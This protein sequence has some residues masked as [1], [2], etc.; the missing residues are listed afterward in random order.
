LTKIGGSAAGAILAKSCTRLKQDGNPLPR[1]LSNLPLGEDTCKGSFNSEGLPN[2]GIDYYISS[3]T[4]SVVSEFRKPY[5]LSLSGLSLEDNL[6]MLTRALE[7]DGVAAIEVNLACPNI[8]GKPIIAYDFDEM[9][10]VLKKI[11]ALANFDNKPVGIKLAPYFDIPHFE[12]AAAIIAKYPIRFVTTINTIGNALFVDAETE[13]AMIVPKNGLGGL[14]GGYVKQTALA[15]V[16]MMS[17][18]LSE[19]GRHDIDVVGV[20]GVSSGKDAF[21]FI[22]CGARAV[23]VA[24]CFWTEG[25][26]CF[27]RIAGELVEIM[28]SKGYTSIEDFRGKLKPYVKKNAAAKS[29]VSDS[30]SL[31]GNRSVHEPNGG[32][33]STFILYSIIALLIAVIAV[34]L[35]KDGKLILQ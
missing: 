14:G 1:A 23:Q 6:E 30:D 8:P 13:S 31:L 24:T 33:S 4:I 32:S 10:R 12:R 19:L 5:L 3:E 26:S 25:P 9:D 2:L 20:G 11:V 17:T 22:L 34:L 21:E 27:K 16:R 35:L 7:A 29:K 28:R 18:K 15:N